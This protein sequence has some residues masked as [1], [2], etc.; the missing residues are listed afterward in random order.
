MSGIN[1]VR[2][3]LE[4]GVELALELG[5]EFGSMSRRFGVDVA[6]VWHRRVVNLD[7]ISGRL[8]A[9]G[10]GS[11]SI[12]GLLRAGAGLIWDRFEG[13][14]AASGRCG[15]NLRRPDQ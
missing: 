1:W 5:F 9:D 12:W 7:A 11:G 2:F 13:K 8:T 15:V 14:L 10:V 6:S 3:G 4:L